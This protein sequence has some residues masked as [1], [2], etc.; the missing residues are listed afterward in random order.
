MIFGLSRRLAQRLRDADP[1]AERVK[2]RRLDMAG[3]V[4]GALRFVRAG[5][6]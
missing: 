4:L 3:S 5:A 6:G 2:L 1:V